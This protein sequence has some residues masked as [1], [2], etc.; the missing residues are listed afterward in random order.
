MRHEIGVDKSIGIALQGAAAV[1]EGA[2]DI[3]DTMLTGELREDL[4]GIAEEAEE[5]ES[6]R[7][8]LIDQIGQ[9][10]SEQ[11]T[12]RVAALSK[13]LGRMMRGERQ[14]V[15]TRSQLTTHQNKLL[16]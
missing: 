5:F 4:S 2:F 12:E 11:D 13:D 7:N 15:R 8:Q 3:R 1:T 14:G 16:Q 9:A 10:G 6:S